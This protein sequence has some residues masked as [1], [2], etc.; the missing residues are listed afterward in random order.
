MAV[1]RNLRRMVTIYM[2]TCLPNGQNYIGITKNL[3]RRWNDHVSAPIRGD[4]P[5]IIL[6]RSIRK[7][8]R[9]AFEVTALF[10]VETWEEAERAEQAMIAAWGTLAPN[11]MNLTAGGGGTVDLRR[12]HTEETK[13]KIG[14]AHKGRII[15][16]ETRAKISA[17]NT[18]SKRTPEQRALLSKIRLGTKRPP[19]TKAKMAE[20]RRAYWKRYRAA[21]PRPTMV[22]SSGETGIY[23][24]VR[25]QCWDIE[26]QVGGKKYRAT[27]QK[28]LSDAI[29]ARDELRRKVNQK[30]L[31][32][33]EK[34]S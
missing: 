34:D 21:H 23:W 1:C 26:I 18:G 3:R 12:P 17:A 22:K 32:D 11:G 14:A 15:S 30:T 16:G 9:D 24:N 8:G 6:R 19:E 20:A 13:A 31:P 5:N 7:Y 10:E 25:R 29:V 2:I 33:H 27:R 4:G 28:E